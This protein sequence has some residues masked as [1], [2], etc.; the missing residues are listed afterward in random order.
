MPEMHKPTLHLTVTLGLVVAGLVISLGI[1]THGLSRYFS[2]FPEN[3][4]I[5]A[6]FG[7]LGAGIP[8]AWALSKCIGKYLFTWFQGVKA[9]YRAMQLR[10]LYLAGILS[11]E[12]YTTKVGSL[13][14]LL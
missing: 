9:R 1:L 13:K 6:Y 4:M 7:V 2:F 8:W 10:K 3:L 11:E 12:E 14:E 5:A